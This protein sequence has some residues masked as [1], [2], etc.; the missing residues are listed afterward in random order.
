MPGHLIAEGVDEQV[1]ALIPVTNE[2]T[3]DIVEVGV[4]RTPKIG[5]PNVGTPNIDS[6]AIFKNKTEQGLHKKDD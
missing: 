2:A 5:T 1:S 4:L 6:N 3:E